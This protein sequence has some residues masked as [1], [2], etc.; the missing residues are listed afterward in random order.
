MM[1]Q[2]SVIGMKP[3]SKSQIDTIMATYEAMLAKHADE[4]E[5]RLREEEKFLADFQKL[6]K[7]VIRPVMEEIGNEIRKSKHNYKI[8]E[9]ERSGGSQWGET[10]PSIGLTIMPKNYKEIDFSS[11][12]YSSPH[13]FFYAQIFSRQIA[14]A[15]SDIMP[16]RG[17]SSG[18]SGEY[19]IGQINRDL[20]ED[21]IMKT[22]KRIFAKES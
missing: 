17:G 6:R 9:N 4:N 2:R 12:T 7:E 20:I 14:V 21:Y 19:S 1:V 11:P 13:V 15:T 22:L 18:P 5:K 16:H 8:T 10:Y 3:E